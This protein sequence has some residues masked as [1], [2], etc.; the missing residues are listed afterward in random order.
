MPAFVGFILVA[1]GEVFISGF[2]LPSSP[3]KNDLLRLLGICLARHAFS[4]R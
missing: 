4:L 2:L 3:E 1:L